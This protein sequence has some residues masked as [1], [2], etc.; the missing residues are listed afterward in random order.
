MNDTRVFSPEK[1][2]DDE[3]FSLRPESLHEF[4]GQSKLKQNLHLAIQAAKMRAQPLDHILFYG[5]P[6]L[7]KTTLSQIISKELGVGFRATSGPVITKTGDLA[8]ILTNLQPRDVLFI[9]EIHRLNPQIEEILYPAMEDFE[10]DIIIGEGPSARSVRI[11]LPPFTLVAATTRAGLITT[12]LR[13]RFGLPLHLDFYT[14]DELRIIIDRLARLLSTPITHA[15]AAE[16]AKR[17]RGTPRVAGRLMRR[18]RDYAV[19]HATGEIDE[20]IANEAL[21]Q[22]DIDKLGLDELDRKY[23]RCLAEFY[24]GGPAG[25]DTLS[26]ALAQERDVLEEV[27][28]PFLVQKGLIQRTARGRMLAPE[29]WRYLGITP[30]KSTPDL[31]A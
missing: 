20:F 12:P 23:M 22:L 30:P 29:A 5:P 14:D 31:F 27:V 10:L 19:V 26:A 2:A 15:G 24:N 7:G 28:E 1:L 3:R 18:V 21:Q 6:G 13:E 25:I 16:I 4:I 9:D 11:D 8:A 17:C